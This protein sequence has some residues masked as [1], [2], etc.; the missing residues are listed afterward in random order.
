VE[1]KWKE[2]QRKG[3]AIQNAKFKMESMGDRHFEF[4][5]LNFDLN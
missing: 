3:R 4:L 1:E 2:R 5:I